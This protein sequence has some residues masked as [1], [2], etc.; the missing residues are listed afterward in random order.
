MMAPGVHAVDSSQAPAA[1][2]ARAMATN[3]AVGPAT[4]V[5][6]ASAG[7]SG[8]TLLDLL[9]ANHSSISSA[10]EMNRLS[11]HAPDRVCACGSTV[12]DCA[13]W[14][15]VRTVIARTRGQVS[16]IAW[17]EC[18]TDVP[19]QR[20]AV[21]LDVP[22]TAAWVDGAVVPADLRRQL[23]GAG[24][25]VSERAI[26]S[27][28]GVRDFKWR[29]LEPAS[30]DG[31]VLR[32]SGNRLDVY[33]PTVTWKNPVRML[34]E[35][36]ELLLALGASSGLALLE[37]CS[38]KAAGFGA[39]ARN[40]WAVADA[41]AAVGNTPFVIDSSKSPL[42]LKRMFLQQPHRVRVVELVRDGRAV[43]ASAMRRRDMSAG[44]AAQIWKRDNQNLAVMLKTVPARLRT[45]VSYEAVCE[46]P[47]RELES[48]CHFLGLDYEP[49]MPS[50]WQRPVH[51]IP[52]NPML[53]DRSRSTIRKDE[54]W[55]RDL[56]PQDVE[57]FERIAGRMNRSFGYV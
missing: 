27:R 30:D 57:A 43:A 9:L 10:G 18:H 23:A 19:P 16:P 12:T 47:K 29:V 32:R 25:A 50:L 15:A 51:N 34:P 36:L 22:E 5:F 20:P 17:D 45:R 38:A 13:Y 24:L 33:D 55:R 1:A 46:N 35:P 4:V 26:L 56:S 40:S 14:N 41:M 21:R 3:G 7:H 54:R 37:A 53:F 8:S 49:G 52:G 48:L 42:R 28:G 11:L 6:I 31:Y 44:K 2:P 39:I